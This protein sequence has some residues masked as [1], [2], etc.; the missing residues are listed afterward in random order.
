MT[1]AYQDWVSVCDELID[2]H[3]ATLALGARRLAILD[4]DALDPTE[5]LLQLA[6]I[7]QARRTYPAERKKLRKRQDVAYR[8][9]A[10]SRL[11]TNGIIHA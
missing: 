6:A 5:A 4:D 1:S 7:D 10:D 8:E 11:G 9:Y 3:D 2:L